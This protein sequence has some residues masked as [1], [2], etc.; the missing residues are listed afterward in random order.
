MVAR[1]V[2]YNWRKQLRDDMQLQFSIVYLIQFEG[3]MKRPKVCGK[4]VEVSL[5]LNLY[6]NRKKHCYLRR[7]SNNPARPNSS[8]DCTVLEEGLAQWTNTNLDKTVNLAFD[9]NTEVHVHSCIYLVPLLSN[10]AR[11][12]IGER[13]YLTRRGQTQSRAIQLMLIRQT[14][15]L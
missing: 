12:C 13:E 9:S 6:F 5:H 8:H 2:C 7:W 3:R 4:S 15:S 10:V 11:V 14:F 1:R